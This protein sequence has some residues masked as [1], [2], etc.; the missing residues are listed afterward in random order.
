MAEQN[1]NIDLQTIVATEAYES[2]VDE[3]KSAGISGVAFLV[4]DEPPARPTFF[5]EVMM[6]VLSHDENSTTMFE[7]VSGAK[8]EFSRKLKLVGIPTAITFVNTAGTDLKTLEPK[9][10]ARWAIDPTIQ[11]AELVAFR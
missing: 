2:F 6:D 1:R 10:R 5:I 4:V 9:I 3:L 7:R 11:S 8:A